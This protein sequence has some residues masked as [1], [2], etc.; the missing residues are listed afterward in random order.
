M[1]LVANNA[2]LLHITPTEI[3]HAGIAK[4]LVITVVTAQSNNIVSHLTEP[5]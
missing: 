3:V 4:N 2:Y 1:P 5:T